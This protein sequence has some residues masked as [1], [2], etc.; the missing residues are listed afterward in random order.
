MQMKSNQLERW[1]TPPKHFGKYIDI[2]AVQHPYTDADLFTI[3]R[4]PY[5][6][7]ISEYY[8][9]W[10]GFQAKYRKSRTREVDLDPSD[11]FNLNEWV[12]D[13]ILQL[14]TA[15]EE[16]QR[17]YSQN[18]GKNKF[19]MKGINEDSETLAQKHYINQAEYI[20]HDDGNILIKH[21]LHYENLSQEFDALM[22]E[23]DMGEIRL[24]QKEE[25]GVYADA[26]N[27]KKRL[28]YRDLDIDSIHFINEYAKPDFEKLGYVMV[29]KELDENYSLG[30]KS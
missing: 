26:Q 8:C 3:V 11:P 15:R 10:H 1:H 9:P 6:R 22:K 23:Y 29:E 17:A 14:G 4:N 7:I 21:I 12:R 5:D 13:T 18:G 27:S 16:F 2:T 24:P 19:Q 20:F 25:K 28:T 30:A